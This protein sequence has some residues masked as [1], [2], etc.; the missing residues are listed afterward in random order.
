MY[1]S[2]TTGTPKG[3]MLSHE[4][5]WWSDIALMSWIDIHADDTTLAF[6]PLFHIAG[7][8]FMIGITWMRGGRGDPAPVSTPSAPSTTSP[9]TG[10]TP[11][12]GCRRCSSRSASCRLR[13]RRPVRRADGRLRRGPGA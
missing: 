4:N 9:A 12:S 13:A 2:G 7:L 10:S 6:S 1:T 8:N 3:V 11:S 5:L